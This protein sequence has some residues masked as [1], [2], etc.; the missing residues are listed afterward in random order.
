MVDYSKLAQATQKVADSK[1]AAKKSA[2]QNR[3]ADSKKLT[4]EQKKAIKDAIKKR[5]Q[6]QWQKKAIKDA[7]SSSG[8]KV[9][10]VHNSDEASEALWSGKTIDTS[11][12]DEKDYTVDDFFIAFE[13]FQLDDTPEPMH[14]EHNGDL[15]TLVFD[16]DISD[17]KRSFC[18]RVKRRKMIKDSKTFLKSLKVK[19]SY[20]NLFKKV[21]DA[22]EDTETTEDAVCAALD[23]IT[24]DTPA[25]DV[26]AAVVEVLGDTI[27]ELQAE[28]E[29]TDEELDEIEDI[30]EDE[31]SIDSEIE[32]SLKRVA[33][34]KRAK[35]KLADSKK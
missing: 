2:Y 14:I 19:D 29:Y 20:K 17:S 18:Q 26:L 15:A 7:F 4:Y 35:S 31:E 34:L 23:T 30:P 24:E 27:D 9:V 6:A 16:E 22:L 12:W 25:E 13:D 10:K 11:E 28:E 33:A 8:K 1:P 21:K 5:K 32:D 3:I